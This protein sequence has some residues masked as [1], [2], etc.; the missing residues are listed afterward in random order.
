[1]LLPLGAHDVLLPAGSCC[2]LALVTAT[3]RACV[4]PLVL[5]RA[6]GWLAL[7]PFGAHR[8]SFALLVCAAW[9]VLLPL[10]AHRALLSACV[11]WWEAAVGAVP[12]SVDRES[13]V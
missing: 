6:A 11:G 3:R 7:L 8:A 13:Y 1:M 9:L 10:G 2:G 4:P 12:Q 5:G